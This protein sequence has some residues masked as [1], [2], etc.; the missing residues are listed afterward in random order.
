VK[1]FEV[2]KLLRVGDEMQSEDQSGDQSEDFF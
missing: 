2:P 1:V